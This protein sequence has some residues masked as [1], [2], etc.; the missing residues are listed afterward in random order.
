MRYN[1]FKRSFIPWV[2][3]LLLVTCIAV[4]PWGDFP[5]NDDWVHAKAVQRQ[6]EDLTGPYRGH[7]F[8]TSS[9]VG[10]VYWGALFAR[11]FGFSFDTLRM[12]TLVLSFFLAWG[13][14]L[15]GREAG[16]P[17][18]LALLCGAIAWSSPIVLVLS[19]SFMLDVPFLTMTVLS[20][21]F[22]LRAL[23]TGKPGNIFWGSVFGGLGYA[24]RQPALLVPIA[25]ACTAGL[26][27]LR[28]RQRPDWRR[29]AAF[30]AG[31]VLMLLLLAWLTRNRETGTAYA[32]EIQ[33]TSVADGLLRSL[34][35]GAIAMAYVGLFVA[36]LGIARLWQLF[37]NQEDN[38]GAACVFVALYTV[39]S[40][41]LFWYPGLCRMPFLPSYL[42]DLGLSPLTL[43]D[44]YIENRTWAPVQLGKWWWPITLFAAVS[45]GLA[46]WSV[47]PVVRG[48]LK[49]GKAPRRRA[50]RT[51]QGLF[52]F[53]WGG[54]LLGSLKNPWLWPHDRYFIAGIPPF[55]LLLA[56]TL[57]WRKYPGIRR[58]AWL[59]AALVYAFSLAGTQDCM[60]WNRARW[61]AID[62][63]RNEHQV[64][65]T[66]INGGYEF[67]GWYTS[68]D[69]MKEHHTTNFWDFFGDRDGR[70]VLDDTYVLGMIA[71]RPGYEVFFRQPFFSWLGMETR[72]IYVFKRD[73]AE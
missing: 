38:R 35:F 39:A 14:A 4:P 6:L 44:V 1:T 33:A 12:S 3:L 68:D 51:H 18:R 16:L 57:A 49:A 47:T 61:T 10:L 73:T 46:L 56:T 53:I 13:V 32:F 9:L 67:Y 29:A 21:L 27:C 7:P 42:Y 41:A 65:L 5:Q 22:Y 15:C 8:C 59:S 50:R 34:R 40:F 58:V 52:L 37:R 62:R 17:R 20:G 63:L 19:Y 36:P 60:A 23:R 43:H 2:L 48:L 45:G 66:S 25:Y 30:L 24:V 26:I 28:R 71:P 70:W 69:F 72:E 11:V 31:L 55:L 54:F 64:P